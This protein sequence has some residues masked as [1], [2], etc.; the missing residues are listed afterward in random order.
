MK[1]RLHPLFIALGL[2]TAVFGGFP[3]FIIYALTALL[4]E[5][6]HIFCAA[7]LGFKCEKISLMPYGAA[8][9][10]DTEGISPADEIKLALSGPAVNAFICVVC[11]GL[12]WFFPVTYAYTDTVFSASAVMLAINL[13]PA[14]PL[15]GGRAI[16]CLLIKLMPEKAAKIFLRVLSGLLSAALILIFFFA[17]KN[18]S[19]LV[20][21]AFLLVSA[22]FEKD[23][24]LSRISYIAK[25]PKRG[26]EIKHVMLSADSTFKD[27]LRHIDGSKYLIIQFY[28]DGIL[29]EICEDELFDMLQKKS[30]YDKILDS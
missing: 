14:Y 20:F 26:K 19:F 11:A 9:V 13:L 15:D 21:S 1:I 25:K 2:A 6:G 17:Y 22:L 29:D 27:A 12:W 5:C 10:C 8:A 7:R 4:H 23:T 3:V 18:L 28:G 16:R 24:Y 30:I